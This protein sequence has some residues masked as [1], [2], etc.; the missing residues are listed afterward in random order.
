MARKNT[1]EA[2]K[3]WQS[4]K[5][6]RKC[7]AIWTSGGILY[8]YNTPVAKFSQASEKVAYVNMERYSV[9]TTVQQR[10]ILSLMN[11]NG[12]NAVECDTLDFFKSRD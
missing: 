6:H 11:S 4:G 9:T 5:N 2:F 12:I 3:A 7:D 10:G 8:S 1:Q